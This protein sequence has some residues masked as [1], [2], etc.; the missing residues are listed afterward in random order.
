MVN[1]EFVALLIQE[2]QDVPGIRWLE[3]IGALIVVIGGLIGSIV[4]AR[5]QLSEIPIQ[6][7]DAVN[8]DR[9]EDAEIV[10]SYQQIA[11][12]QAIE[13]QKLL[14]EIEA[15]RVQTAKDIDAERAAMQVYRS[16]LDERDSELREKE[17]IITMRDHLILDYQDWIARL[18]LQIRSLGDY[19]PVPF[20]SS[21]KDVD[22]KLWSDVERGTG[23]LSLSRKE[24]GGNEG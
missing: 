7:Q 8:K 12:A 20:R 13:N 9:E 6:Q 11:T 14:R 2:L 19:K 16:K 3:A 18:R 15:V 24:K 23:P 5:K 10:K 17:E 1:T 21:Y 22:T 4:A